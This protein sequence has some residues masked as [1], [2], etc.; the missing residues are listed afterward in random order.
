MIFLQLWDSLLVFAC[1]FS[2]TL[3]NL[4]QQQNKNLEF[5]CWR[6]SSCDV[7]IYTRG[8]QPFFG[9]TPKSESWSPPL[10]LT[11]SCSVAPAEPRPGWDCGGQRRREP[12][13]LYTARA[14][15]AGGAD[16]LQP[17]FRLGA[18]DLYYT[19]SLIESMPVPNKNSKRGHY[20]LMP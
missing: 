17:W 1:G 2:C 6:C 14:L 13:R 4:C 19:I 15:Q 5:C 11:Y 20:C 3:E 8:S 7:S 12:H 10:Q 18:T 16:L 9:C